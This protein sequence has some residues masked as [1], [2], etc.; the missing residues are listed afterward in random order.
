M[1]SSCPRVPREK[2]R[3]IEVRLLARFASLVELRAHREL[4]PLEPL[5]PEIDRRPSGCG[6]PREVSVTEYTLRHGPS[7]VLLTRYRGCC[8]TRCR[9]S[10]ERR[11]WQC[12]KELSPLRCAKDI[13]VEERAGRFAPLAASSFPVFDPGGGE[14]K[15]R[16]FHLDLDGDQSPEVVRWEELRQY[17]HTEW[18]VTAFSAT[19]AG[20]R[21]VVDIRFHHT[22]PWRP[23]LN[24]SD[25][26]HRGIRDI[27]IAQQEYDHLRRQ[28]VVRRRVY[29]YDKLLGR[30]ALADTRVT[31]P[32]GL[33]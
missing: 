19:R 14:P 11:E 25:R 26:D 28:V 2:P 24:F 1:V 18:L 31:S 13:L 16:V 33:P 27:E 10:P 5:F 15:T 9:R 29:R 8:E 6:G 17:Y 30:Y 21:R 32:P 12:G 20:L 3:P 23:D 22:G 4:S 7:R